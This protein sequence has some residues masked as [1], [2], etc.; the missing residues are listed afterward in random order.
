[1]K[2]S[3]SL[4]EWRTS[5]KE[6][7]DTASVM[8]YEEKF[9]KILNNH[10]AAIPKRTINKV[11]DYK[12]KTVY[13]NQQEAGFH[14]IEQV[15]S[16]ETEA[17]FVLRVNLQKDSGRWTFQQFKNGKEI[18]AQQ[19]SGFNNLLNV[20]SPYVVLPP[21][22]SSAYN[23]LLESEPDIEAEL[24]DMSFAEEFKLYESLFN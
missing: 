2:N 12:I 18:A 14:Y 21:K 9:K 11:L 15:Q 8:S 23:E 1:M 19:G 13:E 17:E 22:D 6:S 5:V 3:R 16:N 7:S 4:R 10:I 24:E 20:M